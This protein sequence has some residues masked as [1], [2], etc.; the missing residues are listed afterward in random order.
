LS[1]FTK[2]TAFEQGVEL[3]FFDRRGHV[4]HDAPVFLRL[5]PEAQGR[6]GGI[7]KRNAGWIFRGRGGGLSRFTK[8]TAFE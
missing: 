3:L 1:R 6:R 2:R 7:T 8:R 5:A 4:Q